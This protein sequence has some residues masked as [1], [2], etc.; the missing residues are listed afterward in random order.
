MVNK[1][2]GHGELN[3]MDEAEFIA[4]FEEQIA[5][6]EARAEAEQEAIRRAKQA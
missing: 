3:A 2:W 4:V 6:D 5:F 1:G